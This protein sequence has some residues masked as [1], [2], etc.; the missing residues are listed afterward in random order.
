MKNFGQALNNCTKILW[1][2]SQDM[3]KQRRYLFEKV[4]SSLCYSVN[5]LYIKQLCKGFTDRD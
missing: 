3:F 1:E 4:S 2:N 5:F